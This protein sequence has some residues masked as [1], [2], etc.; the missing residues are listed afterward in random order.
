MAEET[1]KSISV[2][3]STYTRF[4]EWGRYGDNHDDILKR[5]LHIAEKSREL[6]KEVEPELHDIP[7]AIQTT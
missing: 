2:K 7:A 6:V 4:K 1:R 5:L 3:E